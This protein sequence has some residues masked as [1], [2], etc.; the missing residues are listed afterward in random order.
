[1]GGATFIGAWLAMLLPETLGDL[2]SDT[3][4]EHQEETDISN[5]TST[6]EI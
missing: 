3:Q 4:E 1:M 2:M 5:L 6:T